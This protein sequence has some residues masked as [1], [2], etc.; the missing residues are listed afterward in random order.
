[1]P[2]LDGR[3]THWVLIG[4]GTVRLGVFASTEMSAALKVVGDNFQ[5]YFSIKAARAS[6]APDGTV[7]E[8]KSLFEVSRLEHDQRIL[9]APGA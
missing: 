8:D 3:W 5:Q 9:D 6:V 1:M 2:A 4:G 7:T